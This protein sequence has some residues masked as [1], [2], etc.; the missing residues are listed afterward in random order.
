MNCI[1]LLLILFCCGNGGNGN[2]NCGNCHVGNSA[3]TGCRP[4]NDC[5]QS[6]GIGANNGCRPTPPPPMP[7]TG[8]PYLEK[9]PCTC[10][11]EEN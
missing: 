10:G 4:H 2:H 1:L 11:C 8:F 9:E 5:N 3:T 7:R 6:N